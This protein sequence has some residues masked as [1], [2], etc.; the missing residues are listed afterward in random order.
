ML[1]DITV[2]P[3]AT[4]DLTSLSWKWVCR[5]TGRCCV[6]FLHFLGYCTINIVSWGSW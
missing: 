6:V 4:S 1:S 3:L 5:S 2:T